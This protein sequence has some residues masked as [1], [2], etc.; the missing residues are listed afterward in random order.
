M[1][2]RKDFLLSKFEHGS[3]GFM[4]YPCMNIEWLARLNLI[5]TGGMCVRESREDNWVKKEGIG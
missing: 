5:R 2:T 3:G 1:V 4:H